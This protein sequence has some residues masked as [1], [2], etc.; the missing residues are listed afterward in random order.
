MLLAVPA[1]VG[2]WSLIGF[3]G[4][5]GPMLVRRLSGSTSLALGGVV[6]FV[7]ASS[8]AWTVLATR[9]RPPQVVMAF[10]MAALV[11]G[12]GTTL[13]ALHDRS[14]TVFFAG[15]VIAGAG[16]GAGFQG[17]I[18]SVLLVAE[19]DA[20]AGVLSILYVVA[21]LAM[22]VPAVLGG[23]RL[24]HGPGLFATAQEYGLVVMSLAA[25]A[26]A[27]SVLR[28]ADVHAA[29]ARLLRGRRRPSSSLGS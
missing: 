1:L 22:G 23:L 2:A 5:L 29:G 10:G 24:V 27:G 13:L 18:R 8:G 3:Y 16:F 6:L 14:M 4:A 12:V 26:L 25:L 17:A 19:P 15:L 9:A 20:R 28:G 21:Y 11:A 7:L